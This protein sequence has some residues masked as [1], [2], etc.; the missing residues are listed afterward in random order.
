MEADERRAAAQAKMQADE[1]KANK[2]MSL[3]QRIAAQRAA[4][5]EEERLEMIR[6]REEKAA[7]EKEEMEREEAER[8]VCLRMLMIVKCRC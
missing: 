2:G 8:Y 5:A 3:M 4:E 1:E 7:R 6:K